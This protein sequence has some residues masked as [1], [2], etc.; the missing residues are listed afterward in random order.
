MCGCPAD[1]PIWD[2]EYGCVPASV[3]D[4]GDGIKPVIGVTLDNDPD[5]KSGDLAGRGCSA[6]GGPF[7]STALMLALC[8]MALAVMRRQSAMK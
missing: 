7:G 2:G 4:A 1:A 3:C 5:G 8:G 6:S